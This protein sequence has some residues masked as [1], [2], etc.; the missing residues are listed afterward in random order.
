[1]YVRSHL[2]ESEKV[3]P[4]M[5]KQSIVRLIA[6]ATIATASVQPSGATTE[7]I[8]I[9]LLKSAGSTAIY[10]AQEKGYFAAEGLD[11]QLMFFDAAEP[12]AVAAVA[13][14]VD[15]G[16][17]GTSAGM[18]SLGAQGALKLIGGQSRE[19]PGFQTL[20]FLVSNRAYDAGLKSFAALGGH[21]VAVAQIGSGSH[22]SVTLIA[23]K[24][25]IDL[26]TI[27]ILPLQS[28]PNQLSAVTGGQADAAVVAATP[29][30]AAIERGDVRLLGWVGDQVPWQIGAIFASSKTVN[31]RHD[32]IER[33]LRAFRK[34]AREYHDAFTGPGEQRQDGAAAPEI[35]AIMAT[36]TGQPAERLKHAI[37]YID[38]E[39]RV[40][41]GDMQRQIDWFRAQNLLKGAPR[42]E[43]MIDKRTVIALPTPA[44]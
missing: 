5:V 10:L 31:N 14:A 11:A 36:Y 2:P 9:G 22:Y 23:T 34:G 37:A 6:C 7:E 26:A 29:V 1:L 41:L 19:Y 24:Y 27:R 32:L 18:F 40:D 38:P 39:G 42:I 17:V 16:S 21:S 13:G 12:I 28:I 44:P 30:L 33:F 8:K 43:D 4:K 35:L 15:I 25:G 3:Q 20:S